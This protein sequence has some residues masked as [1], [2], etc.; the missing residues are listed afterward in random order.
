M[1]VNSH[2]QFMFVKYSSY[3]QSLRYIF[4]QTLMTIK[5]IG[6]IST[7]VAQRSNNLIPNGN[8]P[9]MTSYRFKGQNHWF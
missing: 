9:L 4:I 1:T 7:Y 5:Y 6:F 8:F 3:D 2:T